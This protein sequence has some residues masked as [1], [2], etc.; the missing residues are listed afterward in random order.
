MLAETQIQT[1]WE[2]VCQ[3][4]DITPFTGVCAL[5]GKIHIAIFRVS[6]DKLYAIQNYCPFGQA[7]ILS[8]GIVGTVGERIVV[9]SPL[10]K[11]QYDLATGE[12]LEDPETTLTTYAV[13]VHDGS[14]QILN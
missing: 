14:V 5:V 2:T 9:A 12:C 7:S 1:D 6:D 3:L 10:Y 4:D 13:R 8:R 11:Q